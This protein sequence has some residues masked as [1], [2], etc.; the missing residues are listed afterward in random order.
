MH[1]YDNEHTI[2]KNHISFTDRLDFQMTEK[3]F[4]Q[5]AALR[6]GTLVRGGLKQVPLVFLSYEL[7]YL[8]PKIAFYKSETIGK[9]YSVPVEI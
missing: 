1:I 3:T 9:R 7:K 5:A 8:A 4:F 2:T 6:Y